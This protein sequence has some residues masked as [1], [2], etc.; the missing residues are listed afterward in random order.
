MGILKPC[1]RFSLDP[2]VMDP[3]CA[4]IEAA[5]HGNRKAAQN[6]LE[7]GADP[8]ATI[9]GWTPLFWAAQ[10]GHIEIVDLLLD[11]GAN[12]HSADSGGFTPLKQAVSESHIDIVERLILRGADVNHCCASDGACTVL[13]T[14]AAFGH[15][16]C[17]RLLLQYGADR[18][19]L[20][21]EGQKPYDI[22]TEC[23]EIEAASLLVCSETD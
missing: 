2:L 14:A 17:I 19:A 22:A 16:E 6:A 10:E 18:S 9:D 15:L 21:N 23:G 4:L 7:E 12:V 8:N 1:P 13:H 5:K 3:N 11:S 20:N